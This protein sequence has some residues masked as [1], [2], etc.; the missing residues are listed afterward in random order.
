MMR[1]QTGAL[2]KQEIKTKSY[3]ATSGIGR[4]EDRMQ[5]MITGKFST[6]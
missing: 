6:G 3:A 2:Y 5:E 4:M 1:G